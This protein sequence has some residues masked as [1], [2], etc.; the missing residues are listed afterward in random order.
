MIKKMF[1]HRIYHNDKFVPNIKKKFDLFNSY[2]VE[3]CTP[4]L[5]NSK[6]PSVLIVHIKPLL[7]PFHFSAEQVGNI[8]KKVEF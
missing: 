5:N 1:V 2:S 3:Q 8:A 7:E 4:L 6:L